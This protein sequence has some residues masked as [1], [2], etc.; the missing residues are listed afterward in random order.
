M[1]QFWTIAANTFMELIRQPV[2]P[3]LVTASAFFEV[4]LACVPY[5]G[6]GD[7]PKMVKDSVLAVMLLAGLL[8]AVLSASASLAREIKFGT[9]LAVLSK[10]VGRARFLLAKYAGL[11]VAMTLMTYI[12]LLGALLASRMAF[13]AYGK[14]DRLGLLLWVLSLALAYALAGLSNYF[15]RR[16]FVSDAVFSLLITATL[17]FVLI[18]FLDKS[19]KVQAFGTGVDWRMLPAG[20]LI[21][22]AVWMLAGLALACSTRLE[23]VATLAVCSGLFLLGLMSPYLFGTLA[24]QGS[25]LGSSLYALLPN[26]QSFW[27]ADAM[28]T[29]Q[30]IPGLWGYVGRALGYSICYTGAALMVALVLFEDRELG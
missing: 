24:A 8:G 23:M 17:G 15:L 12:N 7:D 6:F 30:P 26:W 4:F 10:P 28:E 1:R 20:L 5:F 18:N 11:A 21:L 22:M 29:D 19:G 2:F 9:A 27:I 25:W 16:P 13:D 14:A 3:L